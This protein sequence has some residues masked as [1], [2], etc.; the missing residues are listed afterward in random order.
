MPTLRERDSLT[1]R[2]TGRQFRCAPLP[3]VSLIVI[4]LSPRFY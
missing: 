2:S 4:R 1:R 3:P